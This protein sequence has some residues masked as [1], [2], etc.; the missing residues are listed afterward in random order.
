MT[1]LKDI[2]QIEAGLDALQKH[3]KQVT[4]K[5]EKL[6]QRVSPEIPFLMLYCIQDVLLKRETVER[7]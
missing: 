7:L 3:L 2:L 4:E 5:K 6:K 1:S